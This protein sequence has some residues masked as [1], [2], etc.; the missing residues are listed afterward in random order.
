[1]NDHVKNVS[2]KFDLSA[3]GRMYTSARVMTT[4]VYTKGFLSEEVMI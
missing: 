3:L 1:M 2:I 4:I